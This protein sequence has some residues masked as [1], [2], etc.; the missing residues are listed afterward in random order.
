MIKTVSL[1]TAK[2]LR[3]AGFRQDCWYFWGENDNGFC[4]HPATDEPYA[5]VG[6]WFAAPTTDELL[7]ELPKWFQW[8]NYAATLHIMVGTEFKWLIS[9]RSTKHVPHST[10]DKELSEALAQM[11]L[12]LKKEGLLK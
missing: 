3:N 9:Y 7:E 4:L 10:L 2:A 12:W 8:Q 1:E 5:L 11:W 6:K